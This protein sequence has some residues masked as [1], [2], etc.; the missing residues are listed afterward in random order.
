V[1]AISDSVTEVAIRG[2]AF[3]VD[4]DIRLRI[5]DLRGRMRDLRGE[6]VVNLDDKR[7]LQ[8]EIG[9]ASIAL[10]ASDLT[11][12]L[13]R[14][15]FGY[16]GS[17]LRDLVVTTKGQQIVQTGVMHKVIDIPFTMTATL[18]ATDQG[19]IRIHSTSMEIC[20]LVGKGLLRAVGAT[21]ED[22]LD[23]RGA[24]GVR[25]EGNDLILDPLKILP[26]PSITGRLTGIRVVG[27]EV[28][29][30]FG[31]ADAPGVESLPP[32][33]AAEHYVYFRGGTIEFGKL[34]MVRADLET[35]DMDPADLFDFYLD[36]YNS[37]LVA[38]YHV[39][40][41]NLGLVSYMPD[42]DD[43]GTPKA[44]DLRPA[45]AQ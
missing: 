39:T 41:R 19:Q 38:G 43:L 37:Q 44:H 11:L 14:Y 36:Y 3:H 42:F 1:A 10:S 18:S 24:T 16:P 6:R 7:T 26:P 4:D 9:S 34:F 8:I 12:L 13:N 35:V 45:P 17:P 29:Q 21:L 31:P 30:T 40:L 5:R 2:V 32:P 27:D 15:V 22:V 20:G 23:L 25:V 28:V 33:V